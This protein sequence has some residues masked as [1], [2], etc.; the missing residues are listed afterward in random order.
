MN[1]QYGGALNK[2]DLATRQA[3]FTLLEMLV[4]LVVFALLM[5]GLGQTVQYGLT[6][7]HAERRDAAGPAML[8]VVDGSLRRLIEQAAPLPFTGTPSQ[9]AFTTT[10]PAGSQLGDRLAD[11]ALLVDPS[12]RMLL[13]WR[14]HLDG[15]LLK[16]PPPL[17]VEVLLTGVAGLQCSYLVSQKRGPPQWQNK[18]HGDA[19]PLLVRVHI[20][21]AD[22]SQWPD[23]VAAP[24]AMAP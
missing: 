14:P 12:G 10:L 5:A 16:S 13:R 15:I 22:P 3:G 8:A 23:L 2:G 6:A 21:F 1:R 7:W 18:I 17:K 24:S 20:V 19:P 9:V 11:V 4:A